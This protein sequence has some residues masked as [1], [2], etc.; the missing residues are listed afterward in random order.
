MSMSFSTA[1]SGA[2]HHSQGGSPHPPDNRLRSSS[3][4]VPSLCP[5]QAKRPGRGGHGSLS[6][7]FMTPVGLLRLSTPARPLGLALPS[8]QDRA[9]HCTVGC[10]A[11]SLASTHRR[12]VSLP[13]TGTRE[14]S[15]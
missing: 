11:V 1:P 15:P 5:L 10:A 2:S 13:K 3:S 12:R 7:E 9:V 8:R 6:Q 4:Q 14:M